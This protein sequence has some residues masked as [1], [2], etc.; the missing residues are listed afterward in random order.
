MPQ[1]QHHANT[2]L[3]ARLHGADRALTISLRLLQF[4]IVDRLRDA[5]NLPDLSVG[6]CRWKT[7]DS[8]QT[9][10]WCRGASAVLAVTSRTGAAFLAVHD[11]HLVSNGNPVD[12]IYMESPGGSEFETIVVNMCTADNSDPDPAG[13]DSVPFSNDNT[14]NHL[15]SFAHLSTSN[16]WSLTAKVGLGK[17]VILTLG[18]SFTSSRLTPL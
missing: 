11:G 9:R 18:M 13:T 7:R 2:T 10:R 8:G 5:T 15:P 1:S 14:G 6:R 3:P 12:Q 16:I 17:G 4:R